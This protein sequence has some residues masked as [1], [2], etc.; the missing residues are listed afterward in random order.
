MIINHPPIDL[1]RPSPRK[2][3]FTS[4]PSSRDAESKH[5]AEA[6]KSRPVERKPSSTENRHVSTG[7]S[8]SSIRGSSSSS[9]S[10]SRG[11]SSSNSRG[12]S[13]NFRGSSSSSK[14]GSSSSRPSSGTRSARDV[15]V[16][17]IDD[18]L[19]LA[20]SMDDDFEAALKASLLEEQSSN[21]AVPTRGEADRKRTFP[22]TNE[23]SNLTPQSS[24]DDDEAIAKV[25]QQALDSMEDDDEQMM[26]QTRIDNRPHLTGFIEGNNPIHPLHMAETEQSMKQMFDEFSDILKSFEAAAPGVIESTLPPRIA[27]SLLR[28]D[29]RASRG[30]S[31][32]AWM[33]RRISDV[34]D[35][36]D[37]DEAMLARAIAESLKK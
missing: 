18:D 3:E 16:I 29:I 17:E 1:T 10:S 14:G 23:T 4:R 9:S 22:T 31:S 24:I 25:L 20:V 28:D 15:E 36:D 21:N 30:S 12:S 33:R 8:S 37:E 26:Q 11:S 6:K 5:T 7:S 34:D 13:S 35:D 32:P 27:S 19:A 2:M